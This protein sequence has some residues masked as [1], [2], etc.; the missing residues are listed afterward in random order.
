MFELTKFV[1]TRKEEFEQIARD[2]K[3]DFEA[4]REKGRWTA[5]VYIGPYIVEARLKSKIC[6]VLKLERL[7]MILKTHDLYALVIYAGLLDE[8]KALP[9]VFANFNTVNLIHANVSWRYK[10]ADVSHQA[11]SN[12]LVDW[13]FHPKDGVVT[14]LRL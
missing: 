13:L 9:R 6:E 8:L 3:E 12:D 10:V 14:W 11:T 4:L 2:R 5:S 1:A 7:P